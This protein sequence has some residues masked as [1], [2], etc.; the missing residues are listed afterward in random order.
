M[1]KMLAEK[2]VMI[3]VSLPPHIC[4]NML[5]C[6]EHSWTMKFR[7]SFKFTLSLWYFQLSLRKGYAL[8]WHFDISNKYYL[9]KPL[10]EK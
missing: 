6:K 5:V 1:G 7:A 2:D 3:L 10:S 9:K 4:E 8:T